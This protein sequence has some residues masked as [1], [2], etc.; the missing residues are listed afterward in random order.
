MYEQLDG[1]LA[2]PDLICVS[3]AASRSLLVPHMGSKTASCSST[4]ALC[5]ST[6]PLQTDLWS[7]E[8]SKMLPRPILE[9]FQSSPRGSGRPKTL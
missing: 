7:Q 1:I 9:R 2:W 5:T 3:S 6:G 4:W 8:T